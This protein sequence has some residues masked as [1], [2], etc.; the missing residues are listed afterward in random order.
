MK[1]LFS[2]LFFVSLAFGQTPN[3]F[4]TYLTTGVSSTDTTLTFTATDTTYAGSNTTYYATLWDTWYDNSADAYKAGKAEA[5]LINSRSGRTFDVERGV[6][7]TTARSFNTSG[8]RYRID[9]VI[10]AT[11]VLP[12]ISGSVS[13]KYLSNDGSS[14]SWS[15]AITTDSILAHRTLI[16]AGRDSIGAHRTF[17]NANR[18]SIIAHRSFENANR[19]SITAH[20][21]A[22][23]SLTASSDSVDVPLAP[24]INIGAAFNPSSTG[25]A[26]PGQWA[27]TQ[28]TDLYKMTVPECVISG[29]YVRALSQTIDN[30][31]VFTLMKNGSATG[32]AVT[33]A[34]N[35]VLGSN[36][37]SS[38][39]F[40][41]GD[42]LSVRVV[43]GSGGTSCVNLGFTVIARM[44]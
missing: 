5:I 20:R 6:L 42:S 36:T 28:A 35:T 15:S 8:R 38:V 13:G 31:V 29:L 10:F 22:I 9:A 40:S 30:G 21:T 12:A 4:F 25:Y 24:F 32:M 2:L 1:K 41:A 43:S 18:D 3:Y 34:D 23:N 33:L 17:I 14:V 27:V 44:K 37:T 7:G 39:P 16:N 19:D 26:S 11:Q